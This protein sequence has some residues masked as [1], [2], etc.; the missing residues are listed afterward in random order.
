MSQ[1][2]IVDIDDVLSDAVDRC[3]VDAE[4]H[5]SRSHRRES[6]LQVMGNPAS[7]G[8]RS[9]T[10]WRTPSSTPTRVPGSS[11]PP[12][13]RSAATTTTSRS[14]SPT[15]ASASPPAELERI[16]ERF[17]RVDY[18]RSRA[19]GGSGLGLAIVKHIAAAHNGDVAVWSQPGRGSTFTM[20][21]P[22]HQQPDT[23]GQPTRRRPAST[24]PID[25]VVPLPDRTQTGV[26]R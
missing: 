9:A 16:F 20:R 5:R 15:T 8:S 24:R 6:G 3:R 25:D 14:P 21:L 22:A 23:A 13:C 7:S 26:T 19:N 10:W 2:E 1:P 11:S 12:T 17:Y 18:A 4:R